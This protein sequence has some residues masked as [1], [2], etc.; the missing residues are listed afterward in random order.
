MPILRRL[1]S[2]P[3]LVLALGQL[4]ACGGGGGSEA[5][6]VPPAPPPAPA[7]APSIG[8]QP[9]DA[10]VIDGGTASF[11]VTAN[12]TAPLSYQW[13][14]N[15]SSIVGAN[16]ASYTTPA[17]SL[18]DSG[19]KYQVLVSGPGGSASSNM[20]ALTVTPI[21][22]S[23]SSQPKATSVADGGTLSLAVLA[24][25]SGPISYQWLRDGSV[26]AGATEASYTTPQ[27]N[28]KD[29]QARY[30]VMLS[31]PAGTL[32]SEVLTLQVTPVPVI[33][34]SAPA[35]TSV[36]DLAAVTLRVTASGSAPYSYQWKRNGQPI[37]NA[38]GASYSL[39]AS[40]AASGDRYSVVVGNQL[41]AVESQAAVLTVDPLLASITA[42]P[43][44]ASI[45]NG[46]PASFAV[47]AAG[48]PPLSYQWQ[49]S[50]DGGQRW[51]DMAG[52]N[53][54]SYRLA[55][56]TLADAD[57]RYRVQVSNLAGSVLSE[58]AELKIRP[59]V[60][61]IA[62]AVG[63]QGNADG[64][65]AEA[66]PG[67]PWGIAADRKGYIYV[68]DTNNNV[69]RRISPDG[70][71]SVYAGKLRATGLVEGGLSEARFWNIREM[72][73]DVSDNLYV[74]D[75]CSIRKISSA[76]Q[77]STLAGNAYQCNPKDG[78]G[79][80][81]GFSY[82]LGMVADAAG[83][84]FVSDGNIAQ[85]VRKVTPD[86]RVT[87]LAGSLGQTGK[88][89]GLGAAARFS[90]IRGLTIDAS[91]NLMVIDGPTIRQV[92]PVGMVSLYAGQPD[93]GGTTE[94]DR[95]GSARFNYPSGLAYD[96]NGNLLVLEFNRLAR[97]NRSG[98][99]VTAAGVQS[100]ELNPFNLSSDG[101]GTDARICLALSI[102]GLPNGE[103]AFTELGYGTVRLFSPGGSV[104]TLAGR[105]PQYGNTDGPGA[106][107][108][109]NFYQTALLSDA[110][111]AM[112][113]ADS[114][115]GRIRRIGSDGV[116]STY[117]GD[118]YGYRDGDAA[119]ARYSSPGAVAR[120]LAGNIYVADTSNQLIRKI[121]P[122]GMVS[123]LAGAQGQMGSV[124]GLGSA[125]RF[126][127]PGGVAV[128]ANGT[129]YVADT[130]NQTIRK[131]TPDGRVST[132]AGKASNQGSAADGQGEQARFSY[133]LGL[134]LDAKGN[135][136]VADQY[137]HAIRMVT[138]DGK[139]S[140]FAGALNSPA[141]ADDQIPYA[142]FNT[143]VALA[144]DG[145]GN[146]Y[147]AD[148]GNHL[149]RRINTAG[150]VST[151]VGL[152]GV[153][154]LRPGVGGAIN[155]PSAV[156]VLPNGRLVFTSEQAVVSD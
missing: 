105:A 14:R 58:A 28:L 78:L 147:V 31:N 155:A 129:V 47:T 92:T 125:A 145:I 103:M 102:V 57:A 73:S 98:S 140:T 134:A 99:V 24:S 37:A 60:R 106:K 69:I 33:I 32:G 68:A 51:Q 35:S 94:G 19:A 27:L 127:Q 34:T 138:P 26:I 1:P 55:G 13:Q 84:L 53:A 41:G 70:Q 49:R 93:L 21:A 81:A 136:Y 50:I 87:T 9:Q 61:L 90:S 23:I 48:T 4:T 146:L 97:I 67:S 63:G 71:T 121:S 107:A 80:D 101:I 65:G 150:I 131:I 30:Q 112:L 142:R 137:N 124:D 43:R 122:S 44:A 123:T 91:G 3:A 126:Y 86:G 64:K 104:S 20:A 11:T 117:S 6:P 109:F 25:G 114:S 85:A 46:S 39:Q 154:A 128:D 72:N 141:Y 133:P 62:G 113:L 12:G 153:A 88:A 135:L 132:L 111:G 38:N 75:G 116:V 89:D 8:T 96:K 66:R 40:Y 2:L 149:I 16:Q 76:G 7:V 54:S 45:S 29:D 22:L 120:D 59:N 110:S 152:P 95:L 119:S 42:Q 83:N 17:L 144:F 79:A 143:P 130:F 56:T 151:V 77:V 100:Y 52:A 10:R 36:S 156:T 139:V 148:Q 18:T 74:S 82:I 108:R 118:G 5:P 15:G 115:N